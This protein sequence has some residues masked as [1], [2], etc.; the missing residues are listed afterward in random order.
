[1]GDTP[2]SVVDYDLLI[3]DIINNK[4]SISNN[5][6]SLANFTTTNNSN[7]TNFNDLSGNANIKTKANIKTAVFSGIQ[8]G[9]NSDISLPVVVGQS[10]SDTTGTEPL[11]I[12]FKPLFSNSKIKI[13]VSVNCSSNDTINAPRFRIFR[14]SAQI[15]LATPINAQPN[16]AT[17]TFATAYPNSNRG[18]N[19]C[20]FVFIDTADNT[21]QRTYKVCVAIAGAD[22]Y[23]INYSDSTSNTLFNGRFISTLTVEEL[24]G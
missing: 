2:F 11:S 14:D 7:I 9:Q 24:Y 17:P 16:N 4:S 3:N 6:Q 15:V 13:T 8:E 22:K 1:M 21:T 23:F 10:G 20:D 5:A 18:V 12:D 19:A